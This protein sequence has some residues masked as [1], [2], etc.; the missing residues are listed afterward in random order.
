MT[1][2]WDL[3]GRTTNG[4]AIGVVVGRPVAFWICIWVRVLRR[5]RLTFSVLWGCLG[6]GCCRWL[7]MDE[8][9]AILVMVLRVLWGLI[10]RA[11]G[12]I[13]MIVDFRV[14]GSLF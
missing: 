8:R 1:D 4:G 13:G 11:L 9:R 12:L 7:G 5:V 6:S 10:G 3:V 14:F 2:A